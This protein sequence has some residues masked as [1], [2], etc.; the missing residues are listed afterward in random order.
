L[1]TNTGAVAQSPNCVGTTGVKD[2]ETEDKAF[3]FV[4][5]GLK[6]L[7]L[8]ALAA[9]VICLTNDWRWYLALL[10]GIGVWFVGLLMMFLVGSLVFRTFRK[11]NADGDLRKPPLE[12]PKPSHAQLNTEAWNSLMSR[13]LQWGERPDLELL[14]CRDNG[15]SYGPYSEVKDKALFQARPDDLQGT[16]SRLRDE[17]GPGRYP[18]RVF[19][20]GQAMGSMMLFVTDAEGRVPP[21][22]APDPA[23]F[24]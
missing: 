1:V 19:I 15:D 9:F 7:G 20:N 23:A 12:V 21:G 2:L 17:F 3:R 13:F 10:V 14:V 4:Y 6:V 18:V 11:G 5:A 22:F 16:V 8:A 24:P